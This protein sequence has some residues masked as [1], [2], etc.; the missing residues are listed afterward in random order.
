M[1]LVEDRSIRQVQHQ[2]REGSLAEVIVVA[3]VVA[4]AAVEAEVVAAHLIPVRGRQSW[5]L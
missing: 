5:Q 3:A 4:V 2:T 1:P